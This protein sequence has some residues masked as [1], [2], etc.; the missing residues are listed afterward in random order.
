MLV[1]A[2]LGLSVL[3]GHAQGS[4]FDP[5]NSYS[6]FVEYSNDSSHI[7][8]GESENRKLVA[9]GGSYSRKL[10]G[11][12]VYSWRY[13]VDVLPLILLRDP[14]LSTTLT[15]SPAAGS[16]IPIPPQSSQYTQ[17]TS[18]QCTSGSGSGN[19]YAVENGVSVIIATYN[20]TSACSDPWTYGAGISPLGQTINFRPRRKLQPFVAANAGFVAFAGTVPASDATQFNFSFEFGAG[21]QWNIKPRRAWSLDYR[22]HHISNAGRGKENPGV[23]NGTFRLACSFGH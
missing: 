12:S 15:V 16:P 23:D 20:Y 19:Y 8:L 4:H 14:S 2:L 10:R 17:L 18:R 5:T 21:L 13:Q 1:G 6:A 3:C 22:Y 11:N 7:L 9:A